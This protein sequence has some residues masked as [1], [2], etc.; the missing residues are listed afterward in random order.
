MQKN[1]SS[2]MGTAKISARTFQNGFSPVML[3]P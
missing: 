1:F 2:L 3:P